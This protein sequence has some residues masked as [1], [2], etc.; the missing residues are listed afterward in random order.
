M[1]LSVSL[2]CL[3]SL[4]FSYAQPVPNPVQRAQRK[5]TVVQKGELLNLQQAVG[6][7]LEKNY[8]VRIARSQEQIA[9]LN[10][11]LGNAGFA[12]VVTGNAQTTPTLANL[13]QDFFSAVQPD[14]RLYGINNRNSTAGVNM[15]WTIFNGLGMFIALDRLRELVRV[16]EV[17]TRANIEQT[18]ADVATAYYD[19]IRQ[20]QQLVSL[21][22]ALDISRDRLEL[23]KA[24][25]EVGTRSKVD[26]L[27]ARVDY[28]ADSSALILQEQTVS[29]A[30]IL[31]NTLLV[32]DPL[33][34]F[35]VRDTIIVRPDLVL[36]QLQQSVDNNN[37]LLVQAA[38]NRRVANYATRLLRAQQLPQLDFL[39]GY[40]YTAIDNQGGFGVRTGRNDVATY[41]L[42]AT[43]PIFNGGNQKRLIQT[44]KIN[45]LATE[46]QEA[47]Q[48]N[49]LQS[50]LAQTFTQYQT[51]L[52]LVNVEIQ[53]YQIAN[54]NVDIAYDR[55]RV[56][57][58]TAVEFRDV[59]RNAVAAQA[60]LIDAEYTA[61]AAEIELLR[62]S[63]TIVLEVR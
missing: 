1:R 32:R 44:A 33:T 55:Y 46:Y 29:G 59:Q 42:R 3:L 7:A 12:P 6:L 52:R 17:N 48:K 53:N 5:A 10:T 19:V 38:L 58:S 24:N 11:A 41:T 54:E 22:Q 60:R 62:L 43:V 14:Q 57:F 23:A 9:R 47:D 49:Q 16:N 45:E 34:E 4:H 51:N 15:T 56:G 18:V 50:A 40:N 35:T 20:L 31:L 8:Q 39:A 28:N 36:A 27:S 25:Y 63:S 21:R 61:K 26:Y 13:R 30:K 37:P 2:F